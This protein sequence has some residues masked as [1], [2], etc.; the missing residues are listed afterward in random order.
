MNELS[1]S[2]LISILSVLTRSEWRIFGRFIHTGMGGPVGRSEQLFRFLSAYYPRFKFGTLSKENLFSAIFPNEPYEDKKL[3]YAMTDLYRQAC[4]YL[5]FC[6]M[7]EN[8]TIADI[9][10]Q[11]I[12]AKRGADKAYLSHY[13]SDE[14]N[15]I[16]DAAQNADFYFNRYRESFIYLNHYLPRKQ[17]S[18]LNP[19]GVAANYLDV[20]YIAQKLQLLCEM[21]NAKN[22]MA[23]NYNFFMQDE[24]IR[25]LKGGA[26]ANIPVIA[27]YFRILMTLI[28]PDNETHF[29]ELRKLLEL[30]S[31]GFE[32]SE[33]SEMYQYLMN[34]CIRRINL[35]NTAYVTVL[36]EIYMI[37]LERK[38]IYNNG[39]ISQWDFKN[40]VA[41]GIRAEKYEWV[42]EFIENSKSELAEHERANAYTYNLAYYFFGT[43]S[44]KKAIASLQQVEFTDLYYQ[45]DTRAILLKCYFELDDEETLLYHLAA[46]RIFLSRNKLIS[47][48]Q[49]TTYRNLIRFT[50]QLVRNSNN[51]KKIQ[52]VLRE[53]DEV[54]QVADIGWLRRKVNEKI[55]N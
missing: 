41:I 1:D 5:A 45:L 29:E 15:D 36:F 38:I 37:V 14:N 23:V 24:I 32:K 54:K 48:Y 39:F 7:Q 49:R 44:Y 19:V 20:F 13:K 11:E 25:Q 2:K 51:Q 12:L 3:R 53:I 52:S 40:I 16:S 8:I 17:R 46:F 30:K 35:G 22:V 28:E 50:N 18:G 55:Q 6:S 21:I 27:I 34:Y 31:T 9:H 26:F 4:S 43:G 47:D 10:L 33:L 42:H